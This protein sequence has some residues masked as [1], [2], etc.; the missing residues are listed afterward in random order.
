MGGE[1]AQKRK[2]SMVVRRQWSYL[3]LCKMCFTDHKAV[4]DYSAFLGRFF[5]YKAD[6]LL[7]WNTTNWRQGN[8]WEK[9]D[10]YRGAN[11]DGSLFYPGPVGPLPSIRLEI[12][13]DG[14][15]D[16]D[17][18][19]ILEK[20]LK[21][22]KGKIP[23]KLR[24]EAGKLLNIKAICGD[25]R[26]YSRDSEAYLKRREAIGNMIDKLQKYSK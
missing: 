16:Y 17:Y 22:H 5:Y 14:V 20:L 25:L 24:S 12:L 8:P 3:A 23:E 6:G 7:Y 2:R 10:T 11:G 21:A 4:E 19:V 26:N 13:R 1:K 18:L 9:A 15:D